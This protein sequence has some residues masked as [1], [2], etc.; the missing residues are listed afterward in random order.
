[1]LLD[2]LDAILLRNLWTVKRIKRSKIPGQVVVR[3]SK[4]QLKQA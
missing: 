3:V 2:T 4:K 1:M